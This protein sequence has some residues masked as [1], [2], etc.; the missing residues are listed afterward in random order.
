MLDKFL[1]ENEFIA[2]Y[3]YNTDCPECEDVLKELENIGK[4][5][6]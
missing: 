1:N 3:F 4:L 2:V 5:L 6:N